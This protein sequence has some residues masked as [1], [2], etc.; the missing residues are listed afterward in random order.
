MTSAAGD[1]QRPQREVSRHQT[2]TVSSLN[3]LINGH[4]A[5]PGYPPDAELLTRQPCIIYTQE[6]LLHC[7]ERT[8]FWRRVGHSGAM[9][10]RKALRL[11]EEVL[12]G[13]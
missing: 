4:Q 10:P 11:V 6:Q 9:N 7:H 2:P 5:T 1:Q 12:N 13:D 8:F 3:V